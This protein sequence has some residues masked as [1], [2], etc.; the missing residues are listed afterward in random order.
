[1]DNSQNT[2]HLNIHSPTMNLKSEYIIDCCQ[3]IHIQHDTDAIQPRTNCY[4]KLLI[5]L[6]CVQL[7]QLHNLPGDT[8]PI[9]KQNRKHALNISTLINCDRKKNSVLRENMLTSDAK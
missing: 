5:T 9:I 3:N 8:S 4:V 2:V 1:M 7:Q 6:T